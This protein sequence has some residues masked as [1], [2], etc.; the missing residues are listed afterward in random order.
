VREVQVEAAA[1]VCVLWQ[2]VHWK[3]WGWKVSESGYG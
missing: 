3:L 1:E 2:A